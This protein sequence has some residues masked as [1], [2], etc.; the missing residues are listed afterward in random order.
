[1]KTIFISLVA[2]ILM[3][4]P[5]FGQETAK[6]DFRKFRIGVVTDFGLGWM[7]PK[8][9]NYSYNGLRAVGSWGLSLDYN[10]TENYS[11]NSG[12][13]LAGYGGKLKYAHMD[14]SGVSG[15]MERKYR[16][17]YLDIPINL[18]LKTNQIGYFTY[19]F[20]IGVVSSFRLQAL[21]DDEF[22]VASTTNS[23]ADIDITGITRLI[24]L[25]YRISIGTEYQISKSF[26]AFG[27]LNYH[28]GLINAFNKKATYTPDPNI[29]ANANLNKVSLTLGF[30]F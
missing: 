21:A 7:S 6:P 14:T 18:K 3:M 15:S 30:L 4:N 19:F 2:I 13:S 29:T 20:Q 11:L 26:S 8:I 9:T 5:V 17:K 24:N 12:F 28:S 10:L 16:L 27:Q 1:M 23:T 22:T 25:G